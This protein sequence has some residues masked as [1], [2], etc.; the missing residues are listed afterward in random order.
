MV[1]NFENGNT[2]G[3]NVKSELMEFRGRIT[4]LE[5]E[6]ATL[7]GGMQKSPEID[8]SQVDESGFPTFDPSTAKITDH[9]IEN[10]KSYSEQVMEATYL[11]HE[12]ATAT[13]GYMLLLT[14]AGLSK[15]QKKV[16][17]ELEDVMMMALKVGS[18]IRLLMKA[19]EAF[20]AAELAG[21]SISPLGMFEV[22]VAG[23]MLAAS[24]GYGSKLR[25]GEV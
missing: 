9:D 16:V 2:F 7:Q 23:G 19:Q 15:E 1:R 24:V 21:A 18:T 22:A 12:A 13:R 5:Q 25:G 20:N 4:A 17:H 10:V 11:M 8:L 14:Q 6:I 3:Q